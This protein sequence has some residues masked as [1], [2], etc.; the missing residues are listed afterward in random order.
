MKQTQRKKNGNCF[1]SH[2][3]VNLKRL[4]SILIDREPKTSNAKHASLN[5]FKTL[6]FMSY[7]LKLTLFTCAVRTFIQDWEIY[8]ILKELVLL[9]E[10]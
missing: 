4:K 8:P 5:G 7:I 2:V 3:S 6:F 1:I 10:G 9:Q